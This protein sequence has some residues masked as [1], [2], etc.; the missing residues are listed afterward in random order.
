MSL[1]NLFIATKLGFRDF[2]NHPLNMSLGRKPWRRSIQD[3]ASGILRTERYFQGKNSHIEG[4]TQNWNNDYYIAE[5]IFI[6]RDRPN[7]IQTVRRNAHY[8]TESAN[9]ELSKGAKG[10]MSIINTKFRTGDYKGYERMVGT[11]QTVNAD[12][13]FSN[14]QLCHN[15]ET[16]MD[17]FVSIGGGVVPAAGTKAVPRFDTQTGLEMYEFSGIKPVQ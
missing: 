11:K 8:Y 13:K 10:E 5:D 9:S 4:F 3:W 1:G 17:E 6:K 16:G 15:P 2:M 7:V 14:Y 12:G